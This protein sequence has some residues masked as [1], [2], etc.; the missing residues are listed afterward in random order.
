MGIMNHN[1][2]R[3]KLPRKLAAGLLSFGAACLLMLF[4]LNLRA[5][6]PFDANFTATNVY[7]CAGETVNFT[8]TTTPG[9]SIFSWTENAVAFATTTNASRTFNTPGNYLIGLVSSNGSCLDTASTIVVVTAGLGSSIAGTDASCFGFSDGAADLTPSGGT[10]NIAL[11][12][13]RT[14]NDYIAA[15]SLAE[16]NYLSGITIEAWVKPST[17]VTSGDGI[18]GAFNTGTGQN[19]FLMGYNY[20]LQRYVYFDDNTFNQ[21]QNGGTTPPNV[22][23]HMAITITNT[24]T[25]RMYINGVL[26]RTANTTAT[27]QP[28]SGDQF[29]IGQEFDGMAT[30]QHF[31][32]CIDEYRVWNIA[33]SGTDI[34]DLFNN[35]CASLSPSNP[36]LGNLMAY[37][38]LNE[39]GGSFIFDRSGRDNHGNRFGTQWCTSAETDW[40]CFDQGTGFNYLWSNSATTEDLTGLGAGSYSVTLTDGAGCQ[41]ADTVVI[42]EPAPVVVSISPNPS[43]T[44]CAGDSTSLTASGAMTYSWAPGTGLSATTGSN[45]SAFPGASTT[46]NVIGTD[47]NGCQDTVDF[48]VTVNA[49][50]TAAITGIDT[51]CAGDSTTLTASGG[52]GYSWSNTASTAATT[53]TPP[54]TTS[55]TVTVTDTN[56]C[57][58]SEQI[59]VSV[60]ALP[61]VAFSG[62]DTLCAGDSTVITASGGVSYTWSNSATT[63]A[64]TLSPAATSSFAVTVTDANTCSNSDSIEIVVNALPV[65]AFSGND[66]ICL[67][68]TTNVTASGGTM[69]NWSS[70]AMTATA[71]LGPAVNTTYTVTVTDGNS[72]VN[73]DSI[74]IVVNALPTAAITGNDSI[75]AGDSTTLTA[76]GGVSYVWDNSATTTSVTIAPASSGPVSVLVTDAN[77]CQD[78]DTINLTVT[79][80]LTA[81][82]A[83]SDPS[84]AICLGD[85]I[86]LNGSGGTG[87]IWSTTA[88]SAAITVAPTT[89]TTYVLTVSDGA[90]CDGIDSLTIVVNAPPATPVIMQMGGLLVT[91][92]GFVNYN[93]TVDGTPAG[94][95][96]DTLFPSA[97]GNVVVTVT[98]SNG[99]TAT[100]QPFAYVSTVDPAPRYLEIDVF[101]N[102]NDGRFTVR[103]NS[104]L[105]RDLELA[106]FDL[107]GRQV[108]AQVVRIPVGAWTGQIDLRRFAKGVYILQIHSGNLTEFKK[109]IV[110]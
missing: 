76:S 5:Q 59:T 104:E 73:T 52:V 92:P 99:C 53:V 44:I 70:G 13:V 10:P 62:N 97:S 55:F 79:P 34:L 75:C 109:V 89:T 22:W 38:S 49:L 96:S 54:T 60:N 106:V 51:I 33:L 67:G 86:T 9:A 58:D 90:S 43:D 98:D 37:Y 27:W 71:P 91:D 78:S 82:I 107:P 81:M 4:P 31:D 102:P 63:A 3:Q 24:N 66:T 61:V 40:G 101:P 56:G 88:T 7:V 47:M 48:N 23:T 65:I 12:N 57:E 14:T 83:P 21:F 85:S 15:N 16:E 20:G 77:G 45:V 36:N 19:R 94:T 103:I 41:I 95:N 32:G 17:N 28:Q 50:P 72:C 84:G 35:S 69:Y 11:E 64:T 68:D 46:F 87:F 93:W 30:S 74:A 8:N 1:R 80:Q 2:M 110:E 26:R 39:G 6:C 18:F 100:S 25:M 29:S 108:Y 42:N 105:G